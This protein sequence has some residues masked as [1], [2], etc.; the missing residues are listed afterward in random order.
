M[1]IVICMDVCIYTCT[2]SQMH[3]YACTYMQTHTN[4]NIYLRNRE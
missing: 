1:A 2:L 3:K 4:T